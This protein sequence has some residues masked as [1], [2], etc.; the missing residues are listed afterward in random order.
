MEIYRNDFFSLSSE[1]EKVYIQV[2]SSDYDIKTFN[3]IIL[4]MPCIQLQSFAILKKALEEANDAKCLIGTYKPRVEVLLS[5]DEMEAR[6]KLNITA[7]EFVENKIGIPSEIIEALNAAG[8]TEGLDDLFL[9]PISVQKEILV[10]KGIP[11]EDGK[12][13]VITYY[14]ITD[15]KPVVKEDG[16]VNHY[17]LNLIDNVNKGD[18]LGEKIPTQEGTPGRTVTGKTLPPK[19]GVDF[20]LKYDTRTVGEYV[21]NGHIVLR[22]LIDGAVK[23]D[24]DKIKVDNHLIVPGDV[25]FQTGNLV[26]DGYITIRGTVKDG[27]SVIAKNDISIM[28]DMGIGAVEKIISKEGSIYIKG[29]I[30]GKGTAVIEAKRNI[31]MKYCNEANVTAG[32]EINVGFYALDSK[33]KAKKVSLDPVYGKIIGGTVMAE[34]QIIAGIIGNKSEKKTYVSVQG[35]DRSAIKTEFELLLTKY[36]DLLQ[37]AAK[38]KQHLETFERSISGSEYY[39]NREYNEC[40]NKYEDIIDGIKLLDDCRKVLQ[41]VLETK[42]EGE[43][44]ISK[45][46]YPE[47][48]IEIKTFQKRINSVVSGSFYA[49]DKELKHN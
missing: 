26:F 6:I 5:G 45:A 25:G 9:K 44:G 22:A 2:Y 3:Q 32:E 15:K 28:G 33:L 12:D 29:G 37:E 16:S 20:K 47:T 49:Q 8:V 35:F 30:Y 36:K 24:G 27:F 14:E 10:A 34:T 13:A 4:D 18:W 21:E 38:L 42:G 17:E 43:I 7:K 31:Y 46:A 11:P 19:R 40:L 48:F 41:Q 23:L 1:D 39:D